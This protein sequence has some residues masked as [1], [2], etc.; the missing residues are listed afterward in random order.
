[1][2]SIYYCRIYILCSQRFVGSQNSVIFLIVH[3]TYWINLSR[4]YFYK[5]NLSKCQIIVYRNF[6]FLLLKFL[7]LLYQFR[8]YSICGKAVK[9]FK[10][11]KKDFVEPSLKFRLDF[12]F[13]RHFILNIPSFFKKKKLRTDRWWRMI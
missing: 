1:M 3:I 13:W 7:K 10:Y 11:W 12:H 6:T 2:K 9:V 4:F 8:I 5:S